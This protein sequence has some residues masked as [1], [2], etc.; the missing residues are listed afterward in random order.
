MSGIKSYTALNQPAE[1]NFREKSAF[2]LVELM[3]VVGLVAV[4]SGGLFALFRGAN[5]TQT[6]ATD[7]L[8]MQSRVLTSQNKIL[9]FIRDGKSFILPR[10]G[11]ETSV[12]AFIDKVGDIQVIFPKRDP[13]LSQKTGKELYTLNHYQVDIKNFDLSNPV[14][15]DKDCDRICEFIEDVKFRLSNANSVNINLTFATE[16]RQFQIV[17]EGGLMNSSDF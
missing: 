6:R 17:F 10:L 7:D 8:Q 5:Q 16:K 1:R 2:T 9:R 14:F 15:I 4:F 13:V 11:E 3:V 12:I